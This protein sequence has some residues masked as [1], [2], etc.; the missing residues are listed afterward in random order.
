[1]AFNPGW[2]SAG[3]AALALGATAYSAY[4]SHA[5]L[6]LTRKTQQIALFSQFQTQYTAIA[7]RFPPEV[8]NIGFHPERNSERYKLLEDYWIFC[9]AEWYATNKTDPLLYGALWNNYCSVLIS[10]ALEVNSLKYVVSDMRKSY[11]L[12]RPDMLAFYAVISSLADKAG[13]PLQ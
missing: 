4:T 1:M 9:F 3:V 6:E 2:I 7:S 13:T 12:R 11:G 10:N 8:L 5:S